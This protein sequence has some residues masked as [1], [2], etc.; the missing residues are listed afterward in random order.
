LSGS[1]PPREVVGTF[2]VKDISADTVMLVG[3]HGICKFVGLSPEDVAYYVAKGTEFVIS[4][5]QKKKD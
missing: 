4:A 1:P 3:D 5:T 2:T